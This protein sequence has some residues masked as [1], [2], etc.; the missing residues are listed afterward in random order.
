MERET[1]AG[2]ESGLHIPPG[3]TPNEAVY[4]LI[5]HY[6]SL[7]GVPDIDRYHRIREPRQG[8]CAFIGCSEPIAWED[9]E[10]RNFLCDGHYLAIKEWIRSARGG[11]LPLPAKN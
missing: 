7:P 2:P 1:G 11:H 9:N 5:I 4:L 6:T 10:G 3:T 8:S